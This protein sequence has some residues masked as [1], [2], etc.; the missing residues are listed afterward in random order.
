MSAAAGVPLAVPI[1]PSD[2]PTTAASAVLRLFMMIT[3]SLRS[4]RTS[5]VLGSLQEASLATLDNVPI[6]RDL[7]SG[8]MDAVTSPEAAP[9][10][11]TVLCELG[12]LGVET[13]GVWSPVRGTRTSTVLA[14]LMLG[15][16]SGVTTEEL[17]EMVWPSPHQPATARQSLANIVL[18]MR[19]TFGSSFIESTGRGYRI[20]DHVQSDRERFLAGI[21][22]AEEVVVGT[23]DRALELVER[24]LGRWRGE[25]WAGLERPDGVE[26]DRA[27]LLQVRTAAIRIRATA[28]IALHRRNA[29]LGDLR[30]L[31]HIDPYDEFARY[32]LV[33]VLTDTGQ[34]AEA[35][36]TIR[37]AHRLF[38]ERGL[39]LD[40]ALSDIEQRLLSAEF[41][42]GTEAEPLPRHA[43][44]FVGRHREI[45]AIAGLLRGSRLVTVHG[46]GGSGKTRLAVQVASAMVDSSSA[47]FVALA[48]TSSPQQVELAF[49][50]GLGLPPNRLDGLDL[51]ERRAALANVAASSVGVL[52]VD[53]CEHVL[54]D[55]RTIVGE[56]LAAPGRLRILATSRVLLELA[57]EYRYPI[58]EFTDGVELF[59]RRSAQH[60]AH[61]ES[62]ERVD[63]VAEICDLVHHL[64]LAIEIAAA[65]TPYRTLDEIAGE[66]GQGVVHRDATQPESRHETMS[67]AIRWSHELLDSETADAFVRLGTFESP[68]ERADAHAVIESD[69]TSTVL[70]A[71]VRSTLV[72]RSD[73]DGHSSYRLAVPVQQYCAAELAR[74]G[75]TTDLAISYADWLLEFTDRPYGDVWWSFSAIDEIGVRLPHAL[76]AVDALST[77]GRI[78]DA[79]RLASRLGGAALLCGYTDELIDIL[80]GLWPA[81][82]DA[83]ATADALL[84]V[85]LCADVARRPEFGPALGLLAAMD[86]EAGDRHRVFVHCLHS[87]LLM[88]AARLTDENYAPALDELRR[89]RECSNELASPI[90]RAHVEKWESGIH[91]FT[92]EWAAAEAAARRALDEAPGT[93]MDLSATVSLCHA[94]LQLGDADTALRYA[95]SHP[96]RNTDT[97]FGDRLGMVAAI[98]RIQRGDVD[99]G[100]AEI[101]AIH[102]KTQRM[103]WAVQRDD[104]AIAIAYIAHLLGHDDLTLQILDT[105]LVGFGPWTG[106]LIPAICRDLHIPLTGRSTDVETHRGGGHLGATTDRILGELQQRTE[107]SGVLSS[108]TTI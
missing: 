85:V 42:S 47:G 13:N 104:L 93:L 54:A 17:A 96:H 91:L 37:E 62:S 29:S 55:V 9:T 4:G 58:P 63:L 101:S 8:S 65:Q 73:R 107:V 43:G 16:R 35:L 100:L 64:P 12:P 7:A 25:P 49:A 84:A 2:T 6:T 22:T 77:A 20:G 41:A 99:L 90:S 24:V 72:E 60:G 74:Q 31:L 53:N 103:P 80:A 76:S 105:G 95:S 52:V 98:A 56:L 88:M 44:D 106:H 89:A 86:G 38:S 15:A 23:P 71:L 48:N 30:E 94:R 75:V 61:V 92:G 82:D 46:P 10:T 45:E 78:N 27:R 70:D 66:L 50:R 21:R 11:G 5:S 87:L 14:A 36:R 28:L 32:H 102:Q 59:R 34:R 26:A 67:A 97:A 79:T 19:S 81:S 3:S 83:E 33:Q 68:F 108:S 57:D 69:E 40:G 18:R 51:A 1:A 39:L